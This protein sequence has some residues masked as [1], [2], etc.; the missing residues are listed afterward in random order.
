MGHY[1]IDKVH[2]RNET[3]PIAWLYKLKMEALQAAA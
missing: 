1:R 3:I 2:K